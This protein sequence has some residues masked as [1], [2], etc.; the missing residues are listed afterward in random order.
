[1]RLMLS[2]LVLAALSTAALAQSTGVAVT[3]AW[4]RASTP[5]AKTGAIYVT[6][7]AGGPDR[8]TGASTPVAETAEV[9]QSKMTNGVME[10]RPVEG[11][12]AVTP[13]TPIHMAPGGYH[14]MLL[15]LKQPLQQGSHVPL[16]LNFE[17]AGAVNVEAVVAGPGASEPPRP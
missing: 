2:A 7:T 12:L 15:G 9:H 11:G 10:M 8:L 17:H 1:M 5:A 3:Q 14:I 13:G 6:V 16:T 4:S